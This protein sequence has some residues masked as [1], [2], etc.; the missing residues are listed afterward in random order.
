MMLGGLASPAAGL[1][2]REKG[3]DGSRRKAITSGIRRVMRP[4]RECRRFWIYTIAACFGGLRASAPRISRT[5][6]LAWIA[7]Q[8]EIARMG[9]RGKERWATTALRRAK[10]ATKAG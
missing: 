7:T 9:V 3:G 1:N 2:E 4:W 6:K 5:L 8:G 10:G